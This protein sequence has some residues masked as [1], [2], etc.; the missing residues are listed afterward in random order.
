MNNSAPEEIK[1]IENYIYSKT[2]SICHQ[3]NINISRIDHKSTWFYYTGCEIYKI[4]GKQHVYIA[5]Y[6]LSATQF[7]T[8]A[9]D[10][11]CGRKDLIIEM[12]DANLLVQI[13]NWLVKTLLTNIS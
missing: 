8:K 13:D 3:Y 9:R 2:K 10:H 11:N 6:Y 7:I 12:L 4:Y 1:V 5:S